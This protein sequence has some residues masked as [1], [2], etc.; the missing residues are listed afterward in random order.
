VGGGA[1]A[2]PP[3]PPPTSPCQPGGDILPGQ[4]SSPEDPAGAGLID[5][6]RRVPPA[7]RDP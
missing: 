6:A 4:P 7:Q 1:G 2:P 3:P 5:Y